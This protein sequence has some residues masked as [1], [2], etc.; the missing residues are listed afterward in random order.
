METYFF[1]FFSADQ[2]EMSLDE[3]Y[4]KATNQPSKDFAIYENIAGRSAEFHQ[5]AIIGEDL[6]QTVKDSIHLDWSPVKSYCPECGVTV[7]IWDGFAHRLLWNQTWPRAV[8]FQPLS[9]RYETERWD[10]PIEGFVFRLWQW[11]S[12]VADTFTAGRHSEAATTTT[13]T[14][15]PPETGNGDEEEEEE[16]EEEEDIFS[17]Y[18]SQNNDLGLDNGD[19]DR[20]N[21]QV[22][23]NWISSINPFGGSRPNQRTLLSYKEKKSMLAQN[24][25]PYLS[26]RSSSVKK[27]AKFAVQISESVRLLN[28]TETLFYATL[29]HTTPQVIPLFTHKL[30]QECVQKTPFQSYQC[31]PH[32][33]KMPNSSKSL[34]FSDHHRRYIMSV[35]SKF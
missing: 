6:S 16:E 10:S 2:F 33:N 25:I 24:S 26:K 23:Y 1:S 12:D 21:Q 20:S 3:F 15:R 29:N 14:Q 19:S 7:K 32:Y 5:F 8:A 27:K 22:S 28:V 34:K 9:T 30:V 17:F 18:K 35:E 13:T 4:T 11:D 31:E